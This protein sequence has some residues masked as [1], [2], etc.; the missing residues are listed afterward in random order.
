MDQYLLTSV[1]PLVICRNV[2]I[3]CELVWLIRKTSKE[4]RL[5]DLVQELIYSFDKGV[6]LCFTVGL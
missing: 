4:Y 2:G 1:N 3:F 6:V 5:Q